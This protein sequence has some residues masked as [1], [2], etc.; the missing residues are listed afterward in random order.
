MIVA[1]AFRLRLGP[2]CI[3]AIHQRIDGV[4]FWSSDS[5]VRPALPQPGLSIVHC[6]SANRCC[7]QIRNGRHAAAGTWRSTHRIQIVGP[8]QLRHI[9]GLTTMMMRHR[10]GWRISPDPSD[11]GRIRLGV[12]VVAAVFS[13]RSEIWIK[14][15]HLFERGAARHHVS[16]VDRPA[17]TKLRGGIVIGV[18]RSWIVAGASEASNN[19]TRPPPQPI[20][21]ALNSAA[22]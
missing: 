7:G 1:G 6:A 4:E 18:S 20:S 11:K 9:G 21:G 15:V 16:A 12:N 22:T 8:H 2:R 14:A 17:G 13:A 5:R 10:E 3:P 19:V